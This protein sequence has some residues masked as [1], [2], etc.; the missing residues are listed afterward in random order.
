[1]YDLESMDYTPPTQLADVFIW[2]NSPQG[3][4]Y[5]RKVDLQGHT[6]ESKYYL[7]QMKAQYE[8]SQ[9]DQSPQETRDWLGESLTIDQL[10]GKLFDINE[11][12]SRY[13]GIVCDKE[14]EIRILKQE[15]DDLNN[16]LSESKIMKFI[17]KIV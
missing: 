8:K 14:S 17:R 2:N 4:D 9:Q 5:W 12:S 6:E 1:M 11:Q 13:W 16:K 7:A 3:Y 10:R 15:I